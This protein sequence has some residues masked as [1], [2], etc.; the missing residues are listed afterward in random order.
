MYWAVPAVLLIG[1]LISR[2]KPRGMA[3]ALFATA[4]VQALIPV[5][6][7]I[8]SPEVSWG[9]AGVIGVFVVNSFFAALFAVSA[10]LFRRAGRGPNESDGGQPMT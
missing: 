8:I 2:F 10:V 5:I 4:F 9:N 3:R 6:A 1:S 7:L